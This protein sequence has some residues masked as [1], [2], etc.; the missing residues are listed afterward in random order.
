[1]RRK[2]LS[3]KE[4]FLKPRNTKILKENEKLR[5]KQ[6]KN[7]IN[8]DKIEKEIIRENRKEMQSNAYKNIITVISNILD[9]IEEQKINGKSNL[10]YVHESSR[11]KKKPQI[12]KKPA[13][14]LDS[15]TSPEIKYNLNYTSTKN[16]NKNKTSTKKS[17][18]KIDKSNNKKPLLELSV[19][20]FELFD[21]H[22]SINIESNIKKEKLKEKDRCYKSFL[23]WSSKKTIKSNFFKPKNRLKTKNISNKFLLSD[24]KSNINDC[25]G[26]NASSMA[27]SSGIS[28]KP[29]IPVLPSSKSNAKLK[30]RSSYQESKFRS[31]DTNKSKIKADNN[32]KSDLFAPFNTIRQ[33]VKMSTREAKKARK[34]IVV[35]KTIEE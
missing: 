15:Y 23:K 14:K 31:S 2:S 8:P 20:N 5:Y 25:S 10:L 6:S 1:M 35:E 30:E 32:N 3:F 4:S 13:K 7:S 18:D 9:N 16:F 26:N 19:K 11:N 29:P 12:N 17:I 24:N 28:I 27:D 34:N 22:S 33:K 21:V